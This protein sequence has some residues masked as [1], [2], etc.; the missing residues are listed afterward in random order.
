MKSRRFVVITITDAAAE[1]AKQIL[2]AE[3]KADWGLRVYIAGGGCCGPSYGMDMD[4]KPGENDTVIEKNGLKV[5]VSKDS[6]K[7]LDD[8]VMDFITKDGQQG[9]VLTGG[10][11]SSCGSGCSTEGSSCGSG[12]A[13]GCGCE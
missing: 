10:Q 9:F 8:K 4:E 2:T 7:A 13:G 1:K 11:S 6:V 3:G 5:F 12:S